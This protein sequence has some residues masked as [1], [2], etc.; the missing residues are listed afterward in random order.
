MKLSHLDL[1]PY[2]TGKINFKQGT[3]LRRLLWLEQNVGIMGKVWTCES[4]QMV[5][6]TRLDWTTEYYFLEHEDMILF[7][8]TWT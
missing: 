2:R 6:F 7:L 1:Y 3:H 8:L 4:R 5:P